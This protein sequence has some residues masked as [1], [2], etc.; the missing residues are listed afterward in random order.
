MLALGHDC[1]GPAAIPWL[2]D[3]RTGRPIARVNFHGEKF[4]MDGLLRTVHLDG[5]RWAVMQS[6]NVAE[7]CYGMILDVRT[8]RVEERLVC[9]P[10]PARLVGK[11]TI[12]F[13]PVACPADALDRISANAMRARQ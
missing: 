5:D 10:T 2:L 11:R 7:Q 12:P 9:V 4:V 13:T 1:S 3:A 6:Q 8:G